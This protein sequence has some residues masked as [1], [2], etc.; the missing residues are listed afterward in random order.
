M[1]Q[2]KITYADLSVTA[3][4]TYFYRVRTL[5]SGGFSPYSNTAS[6]T[7]PAPAAPTAADI[8]LW[9]AEA[10]VKVG[11]WS[12]VADATAAGGNR[13]ANPDA[14]AAK[15]TTASANPANY[16]EMTFNAQAGV[17]YRLWMRG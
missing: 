7:T 3:Q 13:I 8:V 1:C 11:A 10:P 4:R 16:F 12:V 14:G 5:N 6:A 2:N 9:A 15:I 17:D